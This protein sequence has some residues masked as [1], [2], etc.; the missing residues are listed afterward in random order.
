MLLIMKK[1]LKIITIIYRHLT[2]NPEQQFLKY[3]ISYIVIL[4]YKN[5]P[6]SV[7]QN[8]KKL[9]IKKSA[10]YGLMSLSSY[11]IKTRV[12]KR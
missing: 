9:N 4:I 3:L 1:I 8:Q 2:I 5:A 7:Y 11:E 12:F 10:D 6:V